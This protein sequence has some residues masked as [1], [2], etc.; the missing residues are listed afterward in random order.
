MHARLYNINISQN[1]QIGSDLKKTFAWV[2]DWVH[3][4]A[5]TYLCVCV[6]VCVFVCGC[7][8]VCGGV[9][10]V[11][12]CVVVCVGGVWC[13]CGVR[14]MCAC[15]VHSVHARGVRARCV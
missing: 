6:C 3:T 9:W 12:V 1:M 4:R 2:S 10:G 7:V 14:V 13:A 8:C 15:G 5:S 11:C